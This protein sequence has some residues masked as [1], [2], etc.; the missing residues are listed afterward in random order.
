MKSSIAAV[1]IVTL[2]LSLSQN[3]IVLAQVNEDKSKN[4]TGTTI[5]PSYGT[6]PGIYYDREPILSPSLSQMSGSNDSGS[7]QTEYEHPN[8]NIERAWQRGSTPDEIVKVGDIENDPELKGVIEI[9]KLTLREIAANGGADI[10]TAPVGNIG[11]FNSMSLNEF[12][13]MFPKYQNM[14]VRDFPIMSE[15]LAKSNGDSYSV[16]VLSTIEKEAIEKLANEAMFENISLESLTEG[17]WGK[18]V[19]ASERAALAEVLKRY[20]EL[21]KVPIDKLFPM[22]GGKIA[23]DWNL[24]IEKAR[25]VAIAKNLELSTNELFAVIPELGDVPLSAL[26]IEKLL[27][28]DLDG[29]ADT[30]LDRV[31][32]VANRYLSELGNLSQTPGT[33]LAVDTA[34]IL[35]TGDVFGRLDI[36]FAGEVETPITYVL[37]GGTKNQIFLPEPCLEKSCKHFEIVEVLSGLAGTLNGFGSVRGKAWVQGSSQEVPGGKGFLRWV[38]GGKERT[39]VPVW[40]T[41]SHVKLSLEDIDEGGD[42]EPATARIWLDF[43]ICVYPPFLGEHCTPHFLSFATPWKV[44]EGG[45]MLVFS[46]SSPSDLVEYGRDRAEENDSSNLGVGKQ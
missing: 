11:L 37:S 24:I 1:S 4:E 46:R 40:T 21:K 18:L 15:T 34:M 35:L 3:S 27:V 6:V 36:S 29:L 10:E 32:K 8:Y 23:G 38:N 2:L 43:Q 41:D 31:P 14:A 7:I 5:P 20:P 17:D 19:D 16:R 42:G 26:P 39:G 22:T 33:M 28:R 30:A 44:R 13:E 45:V 25:Q 12:L 9:E